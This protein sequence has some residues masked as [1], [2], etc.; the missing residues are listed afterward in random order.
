[1]LLRKWREGKGSREEYG[2]GKREYRRLCERRKE[3]KREELIEAREAKTQ[4]Q[5]WRVI[6]RERRRKAEINNRIEMREWDEYFR[7]ILGGTEEEERSEWR[8]SGGESEDREE[9]ELSLLARDTAGDRK[10]EKRKGDRGGRDTKEALGRICQGIWRGEGFP[11][12]WREGII[13][14]I[15]KKRGAR[16]VGEHRGV[17]LMSSAY[18][19]CAAVL[20]NRLER[21]IEER[22]IVPKS[23]AG[24][25][26]GRGM[27]D[28]T[29]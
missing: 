8:K 3:E 1:M 22:G 23:Q 13:V 2:R 9:E 11:E 15:A 14:P 10:S 4:N 29:R 17:T 7:D 25:R 24:F 26:K 12:R 6:N 21:E 18:K 27:M 20:A 19:I 16:E 5:V 28:N